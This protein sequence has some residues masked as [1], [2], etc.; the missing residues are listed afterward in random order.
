MRLAAFAKLLGVSNVE[1]SYEYLERGDRGDIRGWEEFVHV[2]VRATAQKRSR[3]KNDAHAARDAEHARLIA[4]GVLLAVEEM[5][6]RPRSVTV[7][8]RQTL[9]E[10]AF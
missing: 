5:K 3:R 2:P 8:V 7:A 4:E 9:V 1:T 10:I 6:E